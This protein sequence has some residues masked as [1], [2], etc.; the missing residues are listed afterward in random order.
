MNKVMSLLESQPLRTRLY[1]VLGLVVAYLV[2]A[3][4]ISSDTADLVGGLLTVILGVAATESAHA[5]V[6]PWPKATDETPNASH[7]D[8]G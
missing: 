8:K 7:D 3:G 1:P 2:S 6:K 5:N 4:L